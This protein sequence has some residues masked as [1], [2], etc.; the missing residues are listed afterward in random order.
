MNLPKKPTVLATH[1]IN[2]TLKT[3][4]ALP[5]TPKPTPMSWTTMVRNRPKK[6]RLNVAPDATIDTNL[7]PQKSAAKTTFK[8]AQNPSLMNK[9]QS[10]S[11]D[12]LKLFFRLSN[13]NEWRKQSPAGIREV[14]VKKL[15]ISPASI[16][17][18]KPVRAGFALSPRN[19]EVREAL[20]KSSLRLSSFGVKLESATSWPP[21]IIPMVPRYIRTEKSQ[22]KVTKE[23]LSDEIERL[24]L[25]RPPVSDSPLTDFCKRC[26]KHHSPKNCSRAP[27]CGNCGSTMHSKDLCMA[28][29]KCRNF[30]AL[31]RSDSRQSLARPTPVALTK[32]A[33]ERASVLEADSD[34]APSQP[35]FMVTENTQVSSVE[36]MARNAMRL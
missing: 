28:L 13:D 34:E 11:T 4:S 22:V 5:K 26:N 21:V 9:N 14:V 20:L 7:Q 2:A 17:L 1:F 8:L 30:G 19:N 23:L 32:A 31:H 36:A 35:E 15:S 16:G 25:P 12:Y 3:T 24:F 29:T 27:S 18:I 33:D 6:T 10:K